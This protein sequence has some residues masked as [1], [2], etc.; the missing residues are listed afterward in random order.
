MKKFLLFLMVLVSALF[1][2]S[3]QQDDNNQNNNNNQNNETNNPEVDPAPAESMIQKILDE[4][5][6]LGNQ[7]KLEG[8]R[9]VTGTVKEITDAYSSQYKNITF[10]LTDG[11]ADILVFRSKGECAATLKVGDTVTVTGEVINYDGTIEFQYAALTTENESGK[12]EVDGLVTIKSVL[13]QAA[14]L[15]DGERLEGIIKLGG[16]VKEITDPYSTQYKNITFILTDGT[17]DI[18]VFRAKGNCAASLKVGD[19]VYV[20]GKVINFGGAIEVEAG[21]LTTGTESD[22]PADGK[23]ELSTIGAVLEAAK[24]L[25]KDQVLPNEYK[26]TG[27]V[28]N[29]KQGFS[30]S[31]GSYYEFDLTDETGTIYV[32]SPVGDILETLQNGDTVF[33][34]GNVK[35]YKGK[36]EFDGALVS[37]KDDFDLTYVEKLTADEKTPIIPSEVTGTYDFIS[38]PM[39]IAMSKDGGEDYQSSEQYYITGWVSNVDSYSHGS[40]TITDGNVSIYAYG[41]T[42]YVKDGEWPLLGDVVVIKATLGTIGTDVELKN[43]SKLVEWHKVSVDTTKYNE[44]SIAQARDAQAEEKLIV[45]GV[46]ASFTYKNAKG[47]DGQYIRDGLYLVSGSKSIYVYGAS[48]ASAVEVGNTIK[49]AGVKEYFVQSSEVDLA[50]KYEFTGACQ[51][52]DV[53]LISNDKGNTSILTNNFEETTIKDLMENGYNENVTTQ[54]YKVN[55]VIKKVPG[56]GFVNYYIND[57]DEKTGTYTYTKCNGNDFAWIDAYLDANAQYVCTMLIAVQNAKATS[58]GCNWRF[59]PIALLDDY[60]FNTD[61][62]A[63]FVLDYIALPQINSVYYANP[64]IELVTSHSSALLGFENATIEY[65]SDNTE[66]LSIDAVEGKLVL[67]VNVL[68]EANVTVTVTCNGHTATHTV[69][70]VREDEPVVEALTVKQAIDT[71]QDQEVTVMGIVAGGVANQ[72][73]AFY[74]IDETGVIAVKMLDDTQLKKVAQGNKVVIKGKREQYNETTDLPGQTC[75]VDAEVVHNYYGEHEYS[76]ATFQEST[77]LAIRKYAATENWT[78]QVFVVEANAAPSGQAAIIQNGQDSIQLYCGGAGQYSWLTDITG[79]S[80]LKMEVLLCNWNKKNPYKAYV[81]AV[82]LEDGTKVVNP[83]NFAQ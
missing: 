22:N 15:G 66:V 26:V 57:L 73:T 44:V 27:K 33:V 32:Y 20:E 53:R 82:Y 54:I 62:A 17:G 61:D 77:L 24:D 5:S 39:A 29:F 58:S 79:S 47:K 83:T 28:S 69:K 7:E 76:T 42:D 10:I 63:Q 72:K 9:T 51:L 11:T 59:M 14:S 21:Q 68:G 37:N 45:E 19:T 8:E 49:V 36:I 50:E 80:I 6:T 60:T 13:D 1:M 55:A 3:C 56:Q 64:A 81:L 25:A 41:M 48:I 74:L 2:V 30:Y 46:V 34:K 12:P 38:I 23:V 52:S 65:V 31:G 71:P 70:V 40:I 18:K 67:N 16:T 43:S 78:T 35:N 75:I 4:A